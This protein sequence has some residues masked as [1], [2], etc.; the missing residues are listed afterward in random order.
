M[1]IR[2][3]VS[4]TLFLVSLGAAQDYDIYTITEHGPGRWISFSVPVSVQHN[5]TTNGLL[6][7][8]LVLNPDF[9]IREGRDPFFIFR[10]EEIGKFDAALKP[11]LPKNTHMQ[12]I[13]DGKPSAE[14]KV[15]KTG[16]RN[17]NDVKHV[18]KF[19]IAGNKR[20]VEDMVGARSVRGLLYFRTMQNEKIDVKSFSMDPKTI[21]TLGRLVAKVK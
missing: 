8:E 7:Y 14:L 21:R 15:Q 20:L 4:A 19:A 5:L 10:F 3:L 17:E 6:G 1:K 2:A 12:F 18:V 9:E 16:F 11:Q 13:I